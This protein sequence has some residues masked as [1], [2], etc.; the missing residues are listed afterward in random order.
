MPPVVASQLHGSLGGCSTH[1]C[2]RG[3]GCTC[4][5]PQPAPSTR[6][7][8]SPPTTRVWVT[9]TATAW[10]ALCPV[11][12]AANGIGSEY[13][14]IGF[15]LHPY[16]SLNTSSLSVIQ[17]SCSSNP[18]TGT[19]P[20]TRSPR[21][22]CAAVLD[23][24]HLYHDCLG[25]RTTSY[26]RMNP[27]WFV[28][29][30]KHLPT[31]GANGIKRLCDGLAKQEIIYEAGS[32]ITT[33]SENLLVEVS[34]E[35]DGSLKDGYYKQL[36][37]EMFEADDFVKGDE[38]TMEETIGVVVEQPK[39]MKDVINLD[40]FDHIWSETKAHLSTR[41]EVLCLM[42]L[43]VLAIYY[44]TSKLED[45]FS[46]TWRELVGTSE[47]GTGPTRSKSIKDEGDVQRQRHPYGLAM[48]FLDFQAESPLRRSFI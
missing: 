38:L 39:D 3:P 30:L 6:P 32:S 24:C 47:P 41:D 20:G 17:L 12:R 48:G 22:P 5:P 42:D 1:A 4:P 18:R 8:R 25:N 13:Q 36:E 14:N 37:S 40:D 28:D 31:L 29:C 43:H 34:Y 23:V 16:L 10:P 2:A 11:A 19:L 45:E 27:R 15:C 7:V 46:R 9:H 35:A 21:R 44:P 26:C 33:E